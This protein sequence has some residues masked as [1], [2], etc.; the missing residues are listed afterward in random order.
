MLVLSLDLEMRQPSG[1]ILQ[2]GACVGDLK[3][4]KVL[5]IFSVLVANK[6]PV[7][8]YITNLTGITEAQVRQNGVDLI[9]AYRMFREFLKKHPL[10]ECNPITWGGGDS[11]ELKK[12]L[13]W[14]YD[15]LLIGLTFNW[16]L[17]RRWTDIK[18]VYQWGRRKTGQSL[19]AGLAKAM[20]RSGLRFEGRPHDALCD[21]VNTFRLAHK[22]LST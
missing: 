21:S 5:D 10:V 19:P 8:E 11:A 18:T 22:L 16:S 12:Q 2:I 4:G 3:T 1:I 14:A 13:G 6:E 20:T 17:G 9:E 15:K 7:S